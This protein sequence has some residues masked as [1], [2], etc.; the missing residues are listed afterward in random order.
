MRPGGALAALLLLAACRGEPEPGAVAAP[1]APEVAVDTVPTVVRDTVLEV[2]FREAAAQI[3]GTVGV[4]ALHLEGNAAAAL[5]GEEPFPLASVSKLAMAYAALQRMAPSDSVEVTAADRAPGRTPLQPGER[6][7]LARVV[8]LALAESDNT[9]ADA[10]LRAAGGPAEV[11]RRMRALGVD[12]VRVDR[13]LR[14]IFADWRGVA[15]TD[16]VAGWSFTEF[17]AR[18]AAVPAQARAAARTAFLDDPRDTG[19]PAAVAAL[20]AALHRGEGLDPARRDLL[21]ETLR[22]TTTGPERI[23]AGVP[24]ETPVAHKTGTLGPLTHDVGIVE[25]P[26][27]RGTLVLAVM[28][29]SA[30]PAAE[31]ERAIAAMARA[32]WG[33]FAEAPEATPPARP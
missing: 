6:T 5:N 8:E 11:T 20:L 2:A 15:A 28:V 25:L 10:L 18:R 9:A 1:A 7:T 12:G 19:T 3:E 4:A 29:R 24:A 21:L 32:A 26:E 13:T 22:G 30:A 27:G 16:S 31:R 33:R 14:E 17:Q 23:R